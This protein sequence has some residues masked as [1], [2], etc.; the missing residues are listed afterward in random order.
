MKFDEIVAGYIKLRDKKAAIKA[1]YDAKVAEIDKVLDKIEAKLIKH[2][3]ETGLE[4]IR[5]DVGTAYKST[6]VSATVGDWDALLAHILDTENYQLLERRVSK[7]AVE[8]YKT[9]NE[10]LPPGV[11][12]REELTVNVRRG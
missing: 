1:E 9:A 11:G 2:F 7:K 3:Q 6:R 4:A 5:T 10:D 12:W 8:E